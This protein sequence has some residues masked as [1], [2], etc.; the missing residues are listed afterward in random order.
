M[1]RRALPDELDI[2]GVLEA[3]TGFR[4]EISKGIRAPVVNGSVQ[5]K[6]CWRAD[7]FVRPQKRW[8]FLITFVGES[9]KNLLGQLAA[10]STEGPVAIGHRAK[11]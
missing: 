9:P 10:L 4:I 8:V 7:C 11:S 5:L 2:Q 6:S 3:D 1:S